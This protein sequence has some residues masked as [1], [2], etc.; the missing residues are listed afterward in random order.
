[1]S[2]KQSIIN[3][4]FGIMIMFCF[5]NIIYNYQVIAREQSEM[6]IFPSYDWGEEDNTIMA[7]LCAN[8]NGTDRE[9]QQSVIDCLDHMWKYNCSAEDYVNYLAVKFYKE[10][11]SHDYELI[12]LIIQHKWADEK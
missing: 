7:Y 9:K 3:A 11:T 10:P 4:L 12:Q 6:Q 2:T 5:G 8:T 1:M